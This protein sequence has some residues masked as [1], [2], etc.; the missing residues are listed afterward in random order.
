MTFDFKKGRKQLQNLML[1]EERN[2]EKL[3]S[4]TET[5]RLNIKSIKSS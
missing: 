5:I 3:L 4:E 1:F 2:F